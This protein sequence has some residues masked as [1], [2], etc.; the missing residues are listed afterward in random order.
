MIVTLS[1]HVPL[2]EQGSQL[3]SKSGIL[4][5]LPMQAGEHARQIGM[6]QREEEE[7]QTLL[8]KDSSWREL[9]ET[10]QGDGSEIM[11]T[12][13]DED[14]SGLKLDGLNL[15]P[16]SLPSAAFPHQSEPST[17]VSLTEPYTCNVLSDESTVLG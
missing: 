6:V 16:V 5:S 15:G 14:L 9:G 17:A 8:P 2:Q 3:T 1:I 11:S 7:G 13:T 12:P 10:Q 4:Y